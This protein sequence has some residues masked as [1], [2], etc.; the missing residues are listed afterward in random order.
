L[1]GL[2]GDIFALDTK[3]EAVSF[4]LKLAH[5]SI[6]YNTVTVLKEPWYPMLMRF[7]L[8]RDER[9]NDLPQGYNCE[10]NENE[11]GPKGGLAGAGATAFLNMF[12]RHACIFRFVFL[13]DM[14]LTQPNYGLKMV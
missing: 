4:F 8:L 2:C 5:S 3:Q 1:G 7:P 12:F 13:P 11:E 10:A 9:P 6:R 14:N